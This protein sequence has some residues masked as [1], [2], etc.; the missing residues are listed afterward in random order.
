M[1]FYELHEGDDDVFSDLLLVNDEQMEPEDFFELVQSIRSRIQDSFEED[2]LIEAIAVELEREH[3]FTFVSDARLSAS[4]HVSTDE[5]ENR[6][7]S[8]DDEIM[9]SAEYRS[10]LADFEGDGS[11]NN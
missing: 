10:I 1:Y 4:V 7:I 2:T 6:L 3:G 9:E 5:D 11:R 8:L